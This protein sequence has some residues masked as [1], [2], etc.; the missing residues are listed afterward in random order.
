LQVKERKFDMIGFHDPLFDRLFEAYFDERSAKIPDLAKVRASRDLLCR[1]IA[2]CLKNGLWL[3][4]QRPDRRPDLRVI[5]NDGPV[6]HNPRRM[7]S[8]L[9]TNEIRAF[10]SRVSHVFGMDASRTTS[11]IAS[12]SERQ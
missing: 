11:A 3:H 2:W 7:S 5:I 1:Y 6:R 10:E 8:P 12:V 9:K 4:T